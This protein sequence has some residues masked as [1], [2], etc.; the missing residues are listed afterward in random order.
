MQRSRHA[1][2]ALACALL[3]AAA[4][5]ARCVAAA[6]TPEPPVRQ[7]GDG[8]QLV[9]DAAG[10]GELARALARASG[11]E[12]M[13]STEALARMRPLRRPVHAASLAA[14]WQ[15]LLTAA[16]GHALQCDRRQCRVWIVAAAP[17]A[18]RRVTPVAAAPVAAAPA[19]TAH[20]TAS[21]VAHEPDPPGLFP[22]D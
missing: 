16:D 8:W 6:P 15:A 18:T 10:S 4:V 7:A 9:P 17:A 12:L 21:S 22:S 1:V 20:A 3:A 19:P 13:A 11:T 2:R 14:A 5:H